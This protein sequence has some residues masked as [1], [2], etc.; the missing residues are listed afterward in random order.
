M[1][2]WEWNIPVPIKYIAEPTMH[3][4]PAVTSHPS[5]TWGRPSHD[6]IIIIII[7]SCSSSSS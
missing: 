3:S 4:M 2:L 1:L 5:G 6:I 7:I